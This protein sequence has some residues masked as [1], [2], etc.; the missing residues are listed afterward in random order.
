MSKESATFGRSSLCQVAEFIYSSTF[1]HGVEE[2]V[3]DKDYDNDDDDNDDDDDRSC[4]EMLDFLIDA[5][6]SEA[7]TRHQQEDPMMTDPTDNALLTVHPIDGSF[8]SSSSF[9]QSTPNTY[10]GIDH[11]VQLFQGYDGP[12]AIAAATAGGEV[13]TITTELTGRFPIIMYLLRSCDFS[14]LTVNAYQCLMRHH[15]KFFEAVTEDV[16]T[17]RKSKAGTNR[18]CWDKWVFDVFTVTQVGFKF[19]FA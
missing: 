17:V 14:K 3:D 13:T 11:E 8:L 12:E 18:S 19:W 5:V 15:I 1:K 16:N 2:V 7:Q 10:G 9:E 6:E 4:E